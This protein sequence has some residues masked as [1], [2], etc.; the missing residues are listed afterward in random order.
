MSRCSTSPALVTFRSSDVIFGTD[1]AAAFDLAQGLQ[2]FRTPTVSFQ[3]NVFVIL[4]TKGK[5]H[6]QHTLIYVFLNF[7]NFK[8][9][10]DRYIHFQ[11]PGSTDL[12]FL[13]LYDINL[14]VPKRE[15]ERYK[16]RIRCHSTDKNNSAFQ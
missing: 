7:T 15:R 11:F 5:R 1:F 13:E 10:D 12:L 9:N 4:P 14:N 3:V 8:F 16:L 2:D 6:Y